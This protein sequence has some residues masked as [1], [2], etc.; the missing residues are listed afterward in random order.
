LQAVFEIGV[1][2]G[3]GGDTNGHPTCF[4][5]LE[6]DAVDDLWIQFFVPMTVAWVDV[7]GTRTRPH[8]GNGVFRELLNRQ[9]H[10]RMG[11][12]CQVTVQR[13]LE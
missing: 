6:N 7:K 8:A 11:R 12:F 5:H 13:R 4:A 3:A 10:P 2:P 1:D 9:R